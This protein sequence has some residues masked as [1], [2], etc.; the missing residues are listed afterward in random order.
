VPSSIRVPPSIS[1]GEKPAVTSPDTETTTPARPADEELALAQKGAAPA[2]GEKP[3]TKPGF[4]FAGDAGGK[5]AAEKLTPAAPTTPWP[6]VAR[7]L[8]QRPLPMEQA[9][10]Q[11]AYLLA[12]EPLAPRGLMPPA[13]Q[14]KSRPL[15][16][17][18]A[19]ATVVEPPLPSVPAYAI[20]A[21][22][23]APSADPE[24]VPPLPAAPRPQQPRLA[25][26][27]D[28]TADA[29]LG[30]LLAPSSAGRTT[31]SVPIPLE[32]PDPFAL[33]RKFELRN[34][35]AE[36]A[37]PYAPTTAPRPTLPVEAPPAAAPKPAEPKAGG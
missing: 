15:V 16:D 12:I 25:P 9:G 1:R 32:V 34:P 22:A 10:T 37:A 29:S 6:Y 5:L 3:V 2:K 8:P 24:K 13:S 11:G 26:N 19:L 30:A 17:L 18:P 31:P 27:T 36:V 4:S 28:P 14:G 20:A 35:P 7:P 21:R 23:Y 33:A